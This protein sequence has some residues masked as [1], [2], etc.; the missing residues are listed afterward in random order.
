[1]SDNDKPWYGWRKLREMLIAPKVDEQALNEALETA[2]SRQPPPVLWLL[3]QTQ[4]GKT[5]LIRALTGSTDAEIGNGFRP[6]TKTARFYDFPTDAPVVRFLDTR[7][8]GEVDYDP[9]SDIA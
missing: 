6:C 4:S 2:S 9:G 1:M 7:G 3:G 8:L 5:S